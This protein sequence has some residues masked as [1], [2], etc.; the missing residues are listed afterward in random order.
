MN[1]NELTNL[2][3]EFA[4]YAIKLPSEFI[5][6]W[7]PSAGLDFKSIELIKEIPE[8]NFDNVLFVFTDND[9]CLPGYGRETPIYGSLNE[10]F[11]D[12][13]VSLSLS[14][15]ITLN[16]KYHSQLER[17]MIDLQ[18][19]IDEIKSSNEDIYKG[20]DIETQDTLKSLGVL[21]DGHDQ[22]YELEILNEKKN[23]LNLQG[24]MAHIGNY[25]LI[26]LELDNQEFLMRLKSARIRPD[27]V[28]TRRPGPDELNF[29]DQ[30]PRYWIKDQHE[31]I[32]YDKTMFRKEV[33]KQNLTWNSS[34]YYDGEADIIEFVKLTK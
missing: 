12:G 27:I 22:M 32:D 18:K 23:E 11:Q 2:L 31:C 34:Q 30:P 7:Y 28:M 19:R 29:M 33:G 26:L 25:P 10:Q 4:E 16:S 20:L 15:P 1:K 6:C 21:D 24:R 8:I 13:D 3:P 5:L 14:A 9:G 17:K